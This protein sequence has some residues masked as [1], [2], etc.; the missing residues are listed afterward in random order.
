MSNEET[1]GET[2][3]SE[4]GKGRPT[5]KRKEAESARKQGIS[6][7]KDPKAARKAARDRDREAR[8][9]SRA[10]LMAGDPAF[11][12]R[13]DA[14]PVK[15]QVRDYIDRRRTVGEFFVP[16][17]F[18]V[19]LLGLVNN[20]T[21]QTT[22]VYVWTSVLLLV[23]LDTILVG[24]LLG[25]SL[26]KDYPEKSDRKGAVSYGVLRAL[27]LRR[28]RIPPPRIKAGGAPITPKIKKK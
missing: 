19:L 9:K 27:Q 12:P 18:V 21:V 26:R 28:F 4:S 7:P 10:G 25:R 8:A 5:P 22:V 1:T 15:A 13:R 2:G 17:A 20:P 3:T 6:V 11:F 14:G 16:F 23:V 24:I